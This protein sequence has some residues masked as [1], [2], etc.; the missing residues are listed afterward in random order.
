MVDVIAATSGMVVSARTESLPGY[1]ATPVRPRYDVV[2]V[3][4]DRG[5][6]YRYSHLFSIEDDIRPGHPAVRRVLH[7]Q[8][9][10]P[11]CPGRVRGDQDPGGE[12]GA[13]GWCEG[14]LRVVI[15]SDVLISPGK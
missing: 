15:G 7:L 3:L 13:R 11:A 6:Y 5:W 10:G 14:A 8:L 2:Y 9:G 1:E 12:C 4:D